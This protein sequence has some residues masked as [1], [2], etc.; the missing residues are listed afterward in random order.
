MKSEVLEVASIKE[1]MPCSFSITLKTVTA[2][3]SET[4][5]RFYHTTWL[6]M[7]YQLDALIIIYS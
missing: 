1:D 4:F 2:G 7:N 6:Y 5:V 3:P